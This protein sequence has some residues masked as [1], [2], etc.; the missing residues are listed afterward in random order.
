MTSDLRTQLLEGAGTRFRKERVAVP[1]VDAELY[2]RELSAGQMQRLVAELSPDT[3]K[4]AAKGEEPDTEQMGTDGFRSAA[5][6]VVATLVNGDGR[7][8]F[9]DG[10]EE[11]VLEAF[12]MSTVLRIQKMAL[13]VNR[14]DESL[15]TAKND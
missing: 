2:V 13:Q 10:D 6:F 12:P 11:S 4:A 15:E 3:L 1:G 8:V 14:G 7:P 5:R 9:Q